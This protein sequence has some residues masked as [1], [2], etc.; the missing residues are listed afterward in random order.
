[1]SSLFQKIGNV[2]LAMKIIRAYDAC[3]WAASNLNQHVANR[4]VRFEG[5][6]DEKTVSQYAKDGQINIADFIRTDY[7][8]YAV[9]WVASEASPERLA[10]VTDIVT[11]ITAIN[12]YLK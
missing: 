7:G 3:Q 4:N 6:V 12:D 9:R 5:S 8:Y 10:D 1:M 2:D 11:A